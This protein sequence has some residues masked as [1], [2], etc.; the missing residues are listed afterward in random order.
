MQPEDSER[1]WDTFNSRANLVLRAIVACLDRVCNY[2][3]SPTRCPCLLAGPGI[4]HLTA[5]VEL[6]KYLARELYPSSPNPIVTIQLA[7][8]SLD[9]RAL[10]LLGSYVSST[11]QAGAFEWQ[12]GILV[13]AMRE[14]KWL[15]LKDID[16]ASAEFLGFIGPLLDS[17]D[18]SKELS[19][20][21]KFTIPN[22][23]QVV[24]AESFA[25]F[26]T[27]SR[28]GGSDYEPIFS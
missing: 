8:T 20:P 11:T 1:L 13:K 22:R 5:F 21:A 16:G 15:V 26:A 3:S 25:V 6:L 2:Y 28:D 7:D 18:D 17:L 19:S 12:V 24:A 23:G 4:T 14:G 27:I 10:L 9:P